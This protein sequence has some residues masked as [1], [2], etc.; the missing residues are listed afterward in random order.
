MPPPV[1][2]YYP[3][4]Y[5]GSNVT[6]SGVTGIR[7]RR[8]HQP[9]VYVT[10]FYRTEQNTNSA[11]FIYQGDQRGNGIFH[12]LNFTPQPNVTPTATELYSLDFLHKRTIQAV[13]SVSVAGVTGVQACLYTGTLDNTGQWSILIPNLTGLP[14]LSSIAHSIM[15]DVVVGN[16]KTDDLFS[17]A[18]IYDLKTAQ[19]FPVVTSQFP[20]ISISAYGVWH[21]ECDSYTIVGG[22]VSSA[23]QPDLTVGF[24]VDWN[25]KSRILSNWRTYSAPNSL[26]NQ[27]T[28]AEALANQNT[29]GEALATHFEGISGVRN[30]YTLAGETAREAYF[31]TLRK[32]KAK[33]ELVQYPNS[34]LTTSDSVAGDILIGSFTTADQSGLQGYI[35]ELV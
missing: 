35:S 32:N 30:G 22:L 20:I 24:V 12:D 4:N 11:S 17:N 14:V 29:K 27:N 25:N 34:T 28:G 3:L 15:G 8:R 21:N 31:V 6:Y 18:F 23:D 1:R 33:W 2:A 7:T 9:K 13:G 26:V 10:G 19:Y 16:Y 5:P